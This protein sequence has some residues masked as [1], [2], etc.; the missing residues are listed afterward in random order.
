MI[1]QELTYQDLRIPSSEI[2]E[3]MGYK[4]SI[5]DQMVIDETN[6]LLKRVIPLLRP[7]FAFFFMEGTLDIEK[8][9][10]SVQ[11]IH[12]PTVNPIQDTIP[13]RSPEQNTFSTQSK[14]TVFSVGKTIARQLRGSEAFVFFAATAGTEFEVFQHTLQQE[15][16]MVKIYIADSLG[17]IIAEKT[18]AMDTGND[19]A[20]FTAEY[21]REK[22]WK[23][24]N[25][26]SPGYCGWH[27]SEQQKLFPLFP[28]AAPCGIRL[29]DS[30]L[31]VPIKSVSGVIGTG[32]NVRKL[33]YTCGLCTYE[34][35]YRKRKHR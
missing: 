17:S 19:P 3:A 31:M 12:P 34:N 18:Y 1:E 4:D 33:E 25:R 27:V 16:D 8:E 21:I 35:C 20:E 5:P 11:S 2:Y 6:T 26:Y 22:N 15:E 13:T 32:T 14:S 23:H 24:T 28:I 9:T 30:S 7:R 10:L 29:T